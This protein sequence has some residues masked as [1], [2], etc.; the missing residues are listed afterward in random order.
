MIAGTAQ[1]ARGEG[2]DEGQDLHLLSRK[3]SRSPIASKP[4][5]RRVAF[6]PLIDRS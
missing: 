5:S 2:E 6:E 4:R 1:P 3:T